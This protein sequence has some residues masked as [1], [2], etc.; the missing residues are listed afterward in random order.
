MTVH[1]KIATHAIATHV[2]RRRCAYDRVVP[3][4]ANRIRAN[5]RRVPVVRDYAPL[6]IDVAVEHGFNCLEEVGAVLRC[7]ESND[8]G[9]EQ[10]F[11]QLPSPRTDSKN[12]PVWPGNVPE[13]HD[14]VPR[15]VVPNHPWNER[16]VVVVDE[17]HRSVTSDFIAHGCREP[18]VHNAVIVEITGPKD[19]LHVYVMAERPES[20]VGKAIVVT[21]ILVTGDRD[22][23]QAVG[24]IGGGHVL[25]AAIVDTVHVGVPGGVCHPHSRTRFHEGL[26]GGHQSAA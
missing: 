5:E 12:L 21:S 26:H 10:A 6:W 1:L 19:R 8:I 22:L 23:P 24:W 3:F 16:E 15:T 25:P 17:H 2:D 9:A 4:D 18:P 14:R 7:L 13:G 20:F 11:E